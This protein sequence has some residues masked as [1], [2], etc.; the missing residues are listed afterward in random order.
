MANRKAFNTA[1]ASADTQTASASITLPGTYREIKVREMGRKAANGG[2]AKEDS[3]FF[4]AS[5]N[6]TL[7]KH[8]D[9]IEIMTLVFDRT[10]DDHREVIEFA[11]SFDSP[12]EA[13]KAMLCQACFFRMGL[14]AE[15]DAIVNTTIRLH[16]DA[17][18][19][20]EAKIAENTDLTDEE[21]KSLNDDMWEAG[22]RIGSFQV[23]GSKKH[24]NVLA[25]SLIDP[26]NGQEFVIKLMESLRPT[27]RDANKQIKK[28]ALGNIK[29]G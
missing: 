3:L 5:S 27:F 28:P 26:D 14:K 22:L 1:T 19:E 24:L 23:D 6:L 4:N 8:T 10:R 12:K 18:R 21:V 15:N 25:N 20:I 29:V 16:T 13:V 2:K 11:E 17:S 7:P 9:D